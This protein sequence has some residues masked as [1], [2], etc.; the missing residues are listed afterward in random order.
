MKT[1]TE[2][3]IERIFSVFHDTK[4]TLHYLKGDGWA[5]SDSDESGC[6]Q[7]WQAGFTTAWAAMLDAV[8]PYLEDD[9]SEGESVP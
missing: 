3:Q 7:A 6:Q 1:Y 5:W 9:Y 2:A 8:E 4:K